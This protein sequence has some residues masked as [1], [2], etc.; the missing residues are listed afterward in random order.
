LN[1]SDLQTVII[2][3]R[4]SAV[5]AMRASVQR[6][7]LELPEDKPLPAQGRPFGNEIGEK[8]RGFKTAWRNACRKAKI[9]G[10]TFHDLRREA[11][12]RLLETPG[13]DLPIV[14]DFLGHD[15]VQQMNTYLSTNLAKRR[16]ALVKW[17]AA[18]RAA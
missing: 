10:L 13:V 16:D 18:R 14:R 8:L 15:N 5:L 11:A 12:S 9:N 1:L 4:L 2:T 17:E 7:A 3:P 6:M